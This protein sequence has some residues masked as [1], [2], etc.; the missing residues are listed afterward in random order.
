MDNFICCTWTDTS[1]QIETQLQKED[2]WTSQ[3]SL[4]NNF[5]NRVFFFFPLIWFWLVWVL[6][7]MGPKYTINTG[8]YLA[9]DNHSSLPGALY[10]F[11]SFKCMFAATNQ[12]ANDLPKTRM[13]EKEQKEWLTWRMGTQCHDL[14]IQHQS[15]KTLWSSEQYLGV[16]LKP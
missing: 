4:E 1:G 2:H 8:K 12:Q 15:A 6:G 14:W 9:Y 5:F 11:E 13:S 3:L 10:S 16:A 7:T